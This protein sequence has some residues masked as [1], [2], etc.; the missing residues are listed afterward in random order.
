M[1]KGQKLVARLNEQEIV[2]MGETYTI[3]AKQKEVVVVSILGDRLKV[4][5]EK[6]ILFPDDFILADGRWETPHGWYIKQEAP[7]IAYRGR[8]R[9]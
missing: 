7:A 6:G 9:V 4:S 1:K 3:S 2:L 5:D 8:A